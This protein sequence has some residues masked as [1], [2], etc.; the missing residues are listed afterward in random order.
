MTLEA[1]WAMVFCQ[2]KSYTHAREYGLPNF[3]GTATLVP[4]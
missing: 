2:L 1:L 4:L 3:V